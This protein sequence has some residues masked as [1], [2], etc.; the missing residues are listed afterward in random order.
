[1][2]GGR[3]SGRGFHR[4]DVGDEIR[5]QK[6]KG[7]Q[8][9]RVGGLVME[10]QTP[11]VPVFEETQSPTSKSAF[12]SLKKIRSPDRYSS[13]PATPQ[14]QQQK[15]FFFDPNQSFTIGSSSYTTPPPSLLLPK[16]ALQQRYSEQLLKYWSE[17][18]NLSPR[19]H[20]MMMSRLAARENR[21]RFPATFFRQPA[22]FPGVNPTPTK[23]YRGVR[24]RHWGKWVSEIR[25]PRNRTRLWLGT[26]DTAEDAA[27]AYD[28]EAFKLRGKNARLNFPGLFI[29]EGLGSNSKDEDSTSELTPLEVS[30][31]N[32]SPPLENSEAPVEV[33]PAEQSSVE[34]E[35]VWSE[36]EEAWFSAWGPGSSVWDDVDGV[37][38][39]LLFQSSFASLSASQ[40]DCVHSTAFTGVDMET[41]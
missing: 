30:K 23:L 19:G 29:G 27:L 12:R 38:N 5:K 14:Q 4:G 8:V 32:V 7:K 37:R 20:M 17:A 15:P 18:L 36:T 9:E 2:E 13:A 31:D 21:G 33:K 28:R 35:V 34:T 10:K 26:F 11:D 39:N 24:Q 40:S 6:G 16:E 22:L 3:K 1:M 25:L 41:S